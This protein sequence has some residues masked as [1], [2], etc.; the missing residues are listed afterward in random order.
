MQISLDEVRRVAKLYQIER[1]ERTYPRETVPAPAS[2]LSISEETQLV[3]NVLNEVHGSEEVR[4]DRI[5]ELKAKIEAG[6]YNMSSETI[7]EAIF[8]RTLADRLR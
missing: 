5:Q 4:E 1:A 3:R 2:E 7:A 6:E 8:K